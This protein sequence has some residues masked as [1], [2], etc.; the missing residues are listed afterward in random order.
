MAKTCDRIKIEV[1]RGHKTIMTTDI[2]RLKDRKY[3]EK[4]KAQTN[5]IP[6]VLTL[7]KLFSGV[8]L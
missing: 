5:T 6:V 4:K 1:I 7:N 2:S 3:K 8:Q